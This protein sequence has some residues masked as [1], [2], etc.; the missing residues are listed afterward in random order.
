MMSHTPLFRSKPGWILIGCDSSGNQA[1]GL[2]HYLGNTEF[3]D[4][5]LNGDIHQYNADILTEIIRT[6]FGKQRPEF[7]IIEP[8]LI[9]FYKTFTVKRSQA[10]RILYAFLFGASGSKLWSYI[11][12]VMAEE[13]GKILKNRFITAVPG[14]KNLTDKLNATFTAT[15]KLNKGDQGYITSLAGNRIYVDSRHKLLVYLLQSAEKIT[16]SS[17]AMLTAEWLEKEGIPYQPCIYYH[18][19]IDFMVPEEYAERA[20]ELGKLA[21]KEGPKM[22]GVNIMDGDAKIGNDWYEVH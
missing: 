16:C 13:M 19:E 11:F 3:T 12:D 1:R 8:E 2:A 6:E 5:L 17:A 21:F 10:K 20:A 9:E 18:D 14:F 15:K 7:G 4:T 22:F